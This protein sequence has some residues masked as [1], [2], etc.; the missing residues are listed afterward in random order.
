MGN[1]SENIKRKITKEE[2]WR[3]RS[4]NGTTKET[5][6]SEHYENFAVEIFTIL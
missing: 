4:C 2:G 6:Q 1:S 3:D 5:L